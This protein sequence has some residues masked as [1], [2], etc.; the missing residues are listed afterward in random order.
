MQRR[1]L[2]RI[3]QGVDRLESVLQ[4]LGEEAPSTDRRATPAPSL[5]VSQVINEAVDTVQ[6]ELSLDGVSI[7]RDI[8]RDLPPVQLEAEYVSRIVADL[9]TAAG[10]R[11]GVG[12][13][14]G[15]RTEIQHEGGQVRHLLVNIQDGGAT[16]QDLPPLE[17]DE[18]VCAALLLAEA[19]GCRI[20]TERRADG[21]HLI[22]LLMPVAEPEPSK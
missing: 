2:Q 21:R 17:E 20:W 8:G 12:D 11:T 1:Y 6:T 3:R 5:P 9:L 15:I 13:D 18:Q 4:E 19:A 14:V 22:T 10:R 16:S 7:S